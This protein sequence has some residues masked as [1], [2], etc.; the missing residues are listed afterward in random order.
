MFWL[1]SGPPW[2]L[3]ERV[4]PANHL[5][6]SCD[7]TLPGTN[8][9]LT[10]CALRCVSLLTDTNVIRYIQ[11]TEMKLSRCSQREKEAM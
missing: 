1:P 6:R 4:W 2:T 10:T 7:P 9:P 11:L 8:V 5:Q 3:A